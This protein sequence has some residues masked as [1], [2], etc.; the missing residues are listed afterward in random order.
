MTWF[1]ATLFT[2]INNFLTTNLWN[3][4]DISHHS[5]YWLLVDWSH[6]KASVSKEIAAKQSHNDKTINSTLYF[7][8]SIQYNP[9]T[10]TTSCM[11]ILYNACLLSILFSTHFLTQFLT[12]SWPFVL[13]YFWKEEGKTKQNK[14]T[15]L[16]HFIFCICFVFPCDVHQ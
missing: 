5:Q 4:S 14:T 1:F 13:S 6:L 10:N 12:G 9:N 15:V 3:I 8:T 16:H 11:Y 2:Q 7:L